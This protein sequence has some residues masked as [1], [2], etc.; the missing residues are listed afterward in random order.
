MVA[1]S[2]EGFLTGSVT[3]TPN[4]LIEPHTERREPSRTR[5]AGKRL[6]SAPSERR[7]IRCH[8]KPARLNAAA[9]SPSSWLWNVWVGRTYD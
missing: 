4:C 2:Y 9:D 3:S 1:D 8:L 5:R 7:R 6:A